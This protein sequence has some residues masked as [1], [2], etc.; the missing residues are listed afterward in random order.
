MRKF[1]TVLTMVFAVAILFQSCATTSKKTTY[2]P[3]TAVIKAST[4]LN[5]Y[6][7]ALENYRQAMHNIDN[8]KAP[9][10]YWE[11][12]AEYWGDSAVYWCNLLDHYGI[13]HT[14]FFGEY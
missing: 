2:R 6:N 3:G 9:L 13:T 7:T 11:E 4:L 5:S 12:E 14:C 8:R 10:F 1:I